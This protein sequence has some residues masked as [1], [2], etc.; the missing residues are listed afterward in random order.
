M[1]KKRKMMQD[2]EMIQRQ[3]GRIRKDVALFGPVV[4]RRF[5]L[6]PE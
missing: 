2:A 3:T 5:Y 4:A 1:L 6:V